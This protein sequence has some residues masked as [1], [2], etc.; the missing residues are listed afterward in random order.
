MTLLSVR[1]CREAWVGCHQ[2]QQQ[3]ADGYIRR[4]SHKGSCSLRSLSRLRDFDLHHHRRSRVVQLRAFLL[5]P[6]LV[7]SLGVP[8]SAEPLPP[9]SGP[10]CVGIFSCSF[11]LETDGYDALFSTS[12]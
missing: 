11:I 8:P 5:V 2:Q 10:G 6:G 12:L 7:Y 9:G 3:Q 4:G 1:L